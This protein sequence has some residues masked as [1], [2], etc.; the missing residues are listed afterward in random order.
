MSV[1]SSLSNSTPR[2]RSSSE[3][4]DPVERT[5]S[6]EEVSSEK[7]DNLCKPFFDRVGRDPRFLFA[8]Q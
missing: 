3:S 7:E 8:M 5:L 4:D 1:A 6:C 2:G